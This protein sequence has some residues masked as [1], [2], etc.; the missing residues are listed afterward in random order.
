MS[1]DPILI[2]VHGCV[3]DELTRFASNYHHGRER[4]LVNINAISSLFIP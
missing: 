4:T 1:I 2:N 3:N